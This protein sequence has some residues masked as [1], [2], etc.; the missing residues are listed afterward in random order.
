MSIPTIQ[1]YIEHRARKKAQDEAF[2]I[3]NLFPAA[4]WS[5]KTEG[6]DISGFKTTLSGEMMV[7]ALTKM[8]EEYYYEIYLKINTNHVIEAAAKIQIQEQN[9]G[10]D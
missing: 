2:R 4:V 6:L 10:Q 3:H 1:E 7:K 8:M 9:D 5:M